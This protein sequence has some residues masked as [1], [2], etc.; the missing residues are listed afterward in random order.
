MPPSQKEHTAE[1]PFVIDVHASPTDQPAHYVIGSRSFLTDR[2]VPLPEIL[3]IPPRRAG[4]S[5]LKLRYDGARRTLASIGSWKRRL[6]ETVRLAKRPG[7]SMP[8]LDLRPIEPGNWSH[9]LNIAF[10][11]ALMVQ[12]RF[13]AEG[14]ADPV[15][16]F[17]AKVAGKIIELFERFELKCLCT[18]GRVK[19]AL[20]VAD[21]VNPNQQILHHY[22]SWIAPYADQFRALIAEGAEGIPDKV[23]LDR[24][25]GRCLANGDLV[26]DFL[27]ERGFTTCY[28]E[29][30]S[31]AQQ[32]ALLGTAS[33]IVA[34][35]GAGIAP[36]M[37]RQPEAGPFR[38]VEI[39]SPGHMTV[40][41]EQFTRSLPAD[42]RMLR[43]RP[44]AKMSATALDL[45]TTVEEYAQNFSLAAFEV[46]LTSLELALRPERIEQLLWA[47]GPLEYKDL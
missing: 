20:I 11:L 6:Y 25:A 17:P 9:A 19:G 8:V 14:L 15:F 41:F 26:R 43:G 30:F 47:G 22:R 2:A 34:I 4:V 29:D 10:P 12:D 46:D 21:P 13:R 42:Y 36:L 45:E 33:Q 44:T 37:F 7:K 18:S 24:R 3:V 38:F 35:H 39:L 32:F 27:H 16:I 23:F 40:Y 28:P 31:I 1:A 5:D